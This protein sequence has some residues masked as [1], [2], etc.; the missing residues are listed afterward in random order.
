MLVAAMEER[1]KRFDELINEGKKEEDIIHVWGDPGR[2]EKLLGV[3]ERETEEFWSIVPI[4]Y[5]SHP[6][7]FGYQLL[8]SRKKLGNLRAYD[9]PVWGKAEDIVKLYGP[10]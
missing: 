10:R 6:E 9:I 4:L 2:Y 5:F 3:T 7:A 1:F 8:G